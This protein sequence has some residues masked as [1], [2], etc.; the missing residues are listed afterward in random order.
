M[1]KPNIL[2][3]QNGK[4]LS[5]FN[6]G[7]LRPVLEL[8]S[9]E[10]EI[11]TGGHGRQVLSCLAQNPPDLVIVDQPLSPTSARLTRQEPRHGGSFGCPQLVLSEERDLLK[12]AGQDTVKR[13]FPLDVVA[14]HARIGQCLGHYPRKHLRVP[15][16]LPCVFSAR[17]FQSF[18]EILSLGTGGAF[19][20]GIYHHLRAGDFV[21]V[22]IPL[23][24]M[25]RELEI[26]SRLVYILAPRQENNYLQGIGIEFVSADREPIR[27]LEDFLRLSL[28]D[29]ISPVFTCFGLPGRQDT[30]PNRS[31]AS[32]GELNSQLHFRS[33]G[34]S[35]LGCLATKKA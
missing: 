15:A 2:L 4:S 28:L 22:C 21:D 3:I 7:R 35:F 16:H 26:R 17:G 23:L 10:V 24:G 13:D 20:K 6:L 18:G 27:V 14:L 34:H 8:I 1:K 31:A 33:Q 9:Y 25:K 11:C 12:P 19:I 30:A 32:L 29:E 5:G